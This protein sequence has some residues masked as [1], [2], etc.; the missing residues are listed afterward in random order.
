MHLDG[1][2]DDLLGERGSLPLTARAA[3]FV[4]IHTYFTGEN[5]RK[6]PTMWICL[7]YRDNKWLVLMITSLAQNSQAFYLSVVPSPE[8]MIGVEARGVAYCFRWKL[9]PGRTNKSMGLLTVVET[10]LSDVKRPKP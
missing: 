4:K 9:R 2:A 6:L 5:P 8:T 1:T 7:C 3:L 10:N